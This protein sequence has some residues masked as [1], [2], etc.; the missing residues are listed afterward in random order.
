MQLDFTWP[1]T[2][3]L[4][5]YPWNR[6]VTNARWGVLRLA[7]TKIAFTEITSVSLASLSGVLAIL[8]V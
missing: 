4:F 5:M 6:K 8:L 2:V 1:K 3:S 7:K